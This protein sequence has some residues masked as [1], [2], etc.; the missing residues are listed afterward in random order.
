MLGAYKASALDPADPRNG[1]GAPAVDLRPGQAQELAVKTGDLSPDLLAD[2]EQGSNGLR[3]L[4]GKRL[5]RLDVG[6]ELVDGPA[7]GLRL[8]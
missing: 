4:G 3:L 8:A 1:H 6:E 7:Q 5:S 2:L